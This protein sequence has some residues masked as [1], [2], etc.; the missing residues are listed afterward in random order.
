MK[1]GKAPHEDQ[2]TTGKLKTNGGSQ[3]KALIILLNNRLEEG[4][5]FNTWRNAEVIILFKNV[6]C[7]NI[8]NT[9]HESE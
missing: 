4:K 1:N 6:N 7:I 3:E 9:D 8:E 2:I 5:V